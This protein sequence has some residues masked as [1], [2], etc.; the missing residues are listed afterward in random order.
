VEDV[1]ADPRFGQLRD[2]LDT[3]QIVSLLECPV[4]CGGELAGVVSLEQVGAPRRWSLSD[5]F[6]AASLAQAASAALE[7]RA[8]T[9]AQACS[10][11]LAFLGFARLVAEKRRSILVSDVTGERE[12]GRENRGGAQPFCFACACLGAIEGVSLTARS[13]DGAT[14]VASNQRP[15]TG[16]HAACGGPRHLAQFYPAHAPA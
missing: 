10:Q 9:Q 1:R 16:P 2:Y 4:W 12:R 7:A 3:H 11:R 6:F 8:R 15:T 14:R 5:E 13:N